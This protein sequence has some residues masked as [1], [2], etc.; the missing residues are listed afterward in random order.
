MDQPREAG[1]P[2]GAIGISLI[3]PLRH[4]GYW[5]TGNCDEVNCDEDGC[6]VNVKSVLGIRENV[7]RTVVK[8]GGPATRSRRATR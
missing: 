4:K 6:D 7:M 2:P 5:D 3:A 1:G 8:I